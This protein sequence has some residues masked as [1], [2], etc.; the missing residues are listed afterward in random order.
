[1]WFPGTV[2]GHYK[3]VQYNIILH[4]ALQGL[5][6]SFELTKYTPYLVLTGELSGFFFEDLG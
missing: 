1:M 6:Q 5:E 3:V 2:V 4:T